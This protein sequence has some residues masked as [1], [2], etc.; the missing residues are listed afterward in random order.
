VK[1]M[2]NT[3]RRARRAFTLIEIL[4]AMSLFTL[5]GF[6]VV[7]MMRTG[8]DMWMRGTRGSEQEDRIEQSLPRLEEDLRMVLVPVQHDRIPFDPQN[9]D[10]ERVPDALPPANRFLSGYM[11]YHMRDREVRCRYIAFVRDIAGLGE[12]ETYAS[13]AGTNSQA[14]AYIDGKDD[15]AEFKANRHLPTGGAVEVLWIWL[16]DRNRLGLGT[17]YRAYRTPVG[18]PG[19]LLDPK[20]YDTFEKLREKVNLQPRFQDVLLF[21]VLFW[22]QYTTTWE[23]D[24]GEPRITCRPTDPSQLTA[25]A[26][27]CGPSRT[28][29]ST[30]GLFPLQGSGGFRLAKG[31]ASFNFSADD[32]WPRMMRVEFALLDEST[33]LAGPLG[34]ADRSFS[35]LATDFATGRG[36]L[37][38]QLMKIGREWVRLV[39][40]S[41]RARDEFELED[42]GL[43]GSAAV[44]HGE[45]TPVYYGRVFDL[46]ISIPS[47]RDDNN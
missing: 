39:G 46:T 30:R 22:T 28:W 41:G 31:K 34:S 14:D 7:A 25:S 35:V 38:G 4:I 26:R 37:D 21:D 43:R 15:E 13:R 36:A 24:S 3:T 12:L 18:G 5:I 29:D 33:R 10:P 45:G 42:R 47:F 44:A 6:A 23:W 8:A 17:V 32:I 2:R 19:S 1:G 27:V 16:P 9:P 11:T 40:R 20:N